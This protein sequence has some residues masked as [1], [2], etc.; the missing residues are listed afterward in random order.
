MVVAIYKKENEVILSGGEARR[1]AQK[2]GA[3]PV[4]E[5]FVEERNVGR[6]IAAVKAFG[7]RCGV[8]FLTIENIPFI[9]DMGIAL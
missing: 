2:L 9:V 5:V 8:R 4:R 7:R 1:D 3:V 6:V